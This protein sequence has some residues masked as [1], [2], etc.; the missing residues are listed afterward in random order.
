M[1]EIRKFYGPNTK[2]ALFLDNCRIHHAIIVKEFAASD[3]IN[4]ELVWNLPYRPDLAGVELTWAEAKR[5]YR[6]E[7]DI[8]KSKDI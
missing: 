1:K 4:I 7:L 3:E 8:L 5:R 6:K 2:L